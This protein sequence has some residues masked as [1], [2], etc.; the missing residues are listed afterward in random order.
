MTNRMQKI[1]S[2]G[3]LILFSALLAGCAGTSA[4]PNGEGGGTPTCAPS[5]ERS[6]SAGG[7]RQG[8][9]PEAAPNPSPKQILIDHLN[10]A[11]KESAG[12]LKPNPRPQ[13]ILIDNFTFSPAKLTVSVGSQVTWINHD[14]VPHTVT[15]TAKP[16]F[17]NSGTMD[18]DDQF[19]HVFQKPGTYDYFCA[20]HPMMTA[21]IIVK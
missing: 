14:D 15:S 12:H 3:V 21:Q 16:K 19:S 8:T 1:G 7:M 10:R 4:E 9:D 11:L 20:L 17:F 5:A 6:D 2:I 13:Q 18:T